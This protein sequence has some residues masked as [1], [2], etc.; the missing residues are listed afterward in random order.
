MLK[1]TLKGIFLK[2]LQ[3]ES[4]ILPFKS[5]IRLLYAEY[6]KQPE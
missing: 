6:I 3:T 5:R 2:V 1:E 4:V